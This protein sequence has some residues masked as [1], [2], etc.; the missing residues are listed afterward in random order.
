MNPHRVL[1]V[2]R[3]IGQPICFLL[4]LVRRVGDL[5]GGRR[6]GGTAPRKILF[7]KLIEQGSTVLAHQALRRAGELVGRENVY[8]W[9][10]E[11]NRFILDAMGLVPPENVVAIRT[12][13]IPRACV[14]LLRTAWRIRRRGIDASVDM[15]F[16]SRAS[17]ILSYLAGA[18]VRVGLH[19][20]DGDG[21]YRGDLMT[22][23]V[24]YNP[25][26]HTSR[27]FVSFVE[28]LSAP[29]DQRPLL[30]EVPSPADDDLPLIEPAADETQRVRQMI[31]RLAAGEPFERLVLLNPN[32]SDLLPL[33][34]WPTERFV[35]LGKLILRAYPD[36]LIGVTGAP[37]EQEAARVVAR[38]IDPQRAVCFAGET[39][40]RELLVLY[41]QARVL[42]TNDSGPAHFAALTPIDVVCLFGPETPHLYAP[43][44]PRSHPIWL[45]LACSPCVNVF[46][47]R[48]S[49]CNDNVCM[50]RIE[51]SRVYDAV[52]AI[53]GD[54][55]EE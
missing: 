50:T 26:L 40:L 27:T 33:R 14:E 29:P 5:F 3:L 38:E 6:A 34:R 42:V 43:L 7:I 21:P 11:E 53:L 51:V 17:A 49:P 12:D 36:V 1:K 23:R 52:R 32:A 39:T 20:F 2:D 9:V 10:F 55:R 46:N 18:R 30:K 28:A 4:T 37:E 8:F 45:G 41:T 44:T 48:F 15:E 31:A 54:G 16:F 13:S 24:H 22:H 47:H 19:R 25:Y 35:E